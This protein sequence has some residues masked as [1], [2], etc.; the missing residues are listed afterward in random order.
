MKIV[1]ATPSIPDHIKSDT[2]YKFT[3]SFDKDKDT[4]TIGDI[5]N[6]VWSKVS[7]FL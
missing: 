6:E 4:F 5:Q 7:T 3:L 2:Y 1:N